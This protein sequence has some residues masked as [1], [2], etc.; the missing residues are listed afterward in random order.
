MGKRSKSEKAQ[1]PVF[2][3]YRDFTPMTKAQWPM[4]LGEN[5]GK[6]RISLVDFKPQPIL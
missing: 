1:P 6:M 4:I 5:V 2:K 3:I